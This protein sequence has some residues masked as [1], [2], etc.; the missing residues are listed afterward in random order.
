MERDVRCG[1]KEETENGARKERGM[2]NV[3]DSG[4]SSLRK[5]ERKRD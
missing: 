5:R 4:C 3:H 1:R 2:S